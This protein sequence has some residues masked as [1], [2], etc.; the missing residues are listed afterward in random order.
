MGEI[1]IKTPFIDGDS[2]VGNAIDL[3]P[4]KKAINI[5][6]DVVVANDRLPVSMGYSNIEM[7]SISTTAGAC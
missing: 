1:N 7:T 2:T 3:S 5:T 6:R 4:T